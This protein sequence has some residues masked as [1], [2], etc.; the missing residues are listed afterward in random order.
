MNPAVHFNTYLHLFLTTHNVMTWPI[1][2]YFVSLPGVNYYITLLQN[3]KCTIKFDYIYV[4]IINIYNVITVDTL[5][6]IIY[7]AFNLI[8][9]KQENVEFE[10]MIT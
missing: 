7:A 5:E 10:F 6:L 9:I 1:T 4:I 8:W 2:V 3:C